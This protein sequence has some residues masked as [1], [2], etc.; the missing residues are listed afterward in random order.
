MFQDKNSKGCPFL[1]ITESLL[2]ILPCSKE[3]EN[4]WSLTGGTEM[5]LLI[6]WA[7]RNMGPSLV[8]ST[9]TFKKIFILFWLTDLALLASLTSDCIRPLCFSAMPLQIYYLSPCSTNPPNSAFSLQ[10]F[11]IFSSCV[12]M[13]F[14]RCFICC[15][16]IVQFLATVSFT[17]ISHWSPKHGSPPKHVAWT[18]LES[19]PPPFKGRMWITHI[20][21]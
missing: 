6:G 1:E 20:K 8:C 7:S 21:L 5:P 13:F 16:P 4:F 10:N 17:I 11:H 12:E 15:H 14:P 9:I 2:P 3:S 19:K 18:V